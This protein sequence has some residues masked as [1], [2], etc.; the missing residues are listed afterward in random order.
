MPCSKPGHLYSI[1]VETVNAGIPYADSFYVVVHYCLE[2][3]T[4]METQLIVYAQIKY[5][6][7]VWSFAKGIIEKNCWQGLEEFY[8]AL[9]KAL[10]IECEEQIHPVIKRKSRRRG[11]KSK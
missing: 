9:S 3:I 6:K 8:S 5:K 2:K 1:D 11:R 4:E 7:N 10:L